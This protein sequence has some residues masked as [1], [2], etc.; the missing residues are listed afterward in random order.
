MINVDQYYHQVQ[1]EKALRASIAQD[2]IKYSKDFNDQRDVI[3]AMKI[4]ERKN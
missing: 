4:V 3:A 1:L 2:I